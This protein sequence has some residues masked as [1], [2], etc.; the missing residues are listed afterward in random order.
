M[1][2]GYAA[3]K[4]GFKAIQYMSVGIPYVVS[5]VG[6]CSEIGI[7]GETHLVATSPSEWYDALERL[8]KDPDLRRKM[9]S[10]GRNFALEHFTVR[11]Q[12]DKLSKILFDAARS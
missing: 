3:G 7:A 12:A 6:V 1:Q 2:S 11:K 9:G 4:S 8:L 10:A 5:P